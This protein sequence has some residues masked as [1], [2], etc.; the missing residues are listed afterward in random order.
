M[1]L[2]RIISKT[3]EYL[4]IP[5]VVGMFFNDLRAISGGLV[6]FNI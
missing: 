4:K 6:V 1:S 3:D 5:S 2:E